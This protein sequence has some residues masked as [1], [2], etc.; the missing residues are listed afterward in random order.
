MY[1]SVSN[2]VG[3]FFIDYVLIL[4]IGVTA[5]TVAADLNGNVEIMGTV[6]SVVG[7]VCIL[8]KDIFG[9]S[10]GKRIFKIKIVTDEGQKPVIYKLILRNLTTFIW[11]I[12]LLAITISESCTRLSDKILGLKVVKLIN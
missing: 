4:I 11:P 7:L 2:R 12:E 3:A 10:I 1:A 9:Q 6:I 5:G 8:F